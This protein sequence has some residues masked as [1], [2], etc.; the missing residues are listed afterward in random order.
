M[1]HLCL[2]SCVA[3]SQDHSGKEQRYAPETTGAPVAS[4]LQSRA[5]LEWR[6]THGGGQKTG[7][8]ELSKRAEQLF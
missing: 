2:L 1:L 5:A 6:Q 4:F 7:G 8:V 3:H